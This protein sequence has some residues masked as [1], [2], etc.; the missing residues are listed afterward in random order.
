VKATGAVLAMA[1]AGGA[2]SAAERTIGDEL[3]LA[4]D[5]GNLLAVK[6]LIDGGADPD[7]PIG[8]GAGASTALIK[9]AW[10]GKRDIVKYLLAKGAKVNAV[11]PEGQNALM[12]AVERGFD[13][14]V[15]LLIAQGA[16][17]KARDGRG[18]TAFSLAASEAHL[19]IMDV[20]LQHG[21]DL[22]A[23]DPYGITPMLAAA[24]LGNEEVLRY[25]VGKGAKVNAIT[26]LEYGGSTALTTAASVGQVALVKALLELGADP[27]LKMK[28]GGTALSHAQESK[29]EEVIA[30]IQAALA[31]ARPAVPARMP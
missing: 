1:L 3:A 12:Q 5:R 11:N 4:I 30:L 25:L 2:L 29:N 6:E 13:D 16:D 10:N 9:A 17:V 15:D 31:K 19:E 20:L 28:D 24:S 27:R 21:A 26:Q 7:T 8:S 18:N 14:V 22:N 23:A